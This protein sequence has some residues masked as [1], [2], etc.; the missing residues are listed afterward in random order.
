M[1]AA[2]GRLWLPHSV[3]RGS[4]ATLIESA[5]IA[6]A[7]AG[8][9]W[10][11]VLV[12]LLAAPPRVGVFAAASFAALG[13]VATGAAAVFL[14]NH[15]RP[16]GPYADKIMTMLGF[17]NPKMVNLAPFS[18]RARA[19]FEQGGSPHVYHLWPALEKY[20]VLRRRG[21]DKRSAN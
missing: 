5:R 7:A 18:E 8:L 6:A 1:T 11:A 19:V 15:G 20:G 14:V 21:A 2:D 12:V 3:C 13:I 16:E 4:Y 17:K 9:A 10:I